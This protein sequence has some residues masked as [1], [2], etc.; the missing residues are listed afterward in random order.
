MHRVEEFRDLQIEATE[1]RRYLHRH[2]EL[3]Y[4]LYNTAKFVTEKLASFG[5]NNI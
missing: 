2:P 4:K 3:D 5:I 1:W